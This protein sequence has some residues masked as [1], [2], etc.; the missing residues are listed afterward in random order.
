MPEPACN[1]LNSCWAAVFVAFCAALLAFAELDEDVE[2][3]V[4]L[5][6]DVLEETVV[7]DDTPARACHA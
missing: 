1:E 6:D 4:V 3:V 2:E 7:I 5:L